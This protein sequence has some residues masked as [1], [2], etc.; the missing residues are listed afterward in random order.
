[1]LTAIYLVQEIVSTAF[2]RSNYDIFATLQVGRI[3]LK[4]EGK[5]KKEDLNEEK[6]EFKMLEVVKLI[7]W[8]TLTPCRTSW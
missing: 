8:D 5:T 1:M 3:I 4:F 7:D 2:L 6:Q